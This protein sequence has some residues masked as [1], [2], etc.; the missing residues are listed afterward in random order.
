MD[1]IYLTIL[2]GFAASVALG[3]MKLKPIIGGAIAA[4]VMP[5]PF[6]IVNG[7]SQSQSSA[8]DMVFLAPWFVLFVAFVAL[9]SFAAGFVGMTLGNGIVGHGSLANRRSIASALACAIVCFVAY[10]GY[11]AQQNKERDP[12]I[13]ESALRF[14]TADPSIVLMAGA[15]ASVS[16]SRSADMADTN[17]WPSASVELGQ[18]RDHSRVDVLLREVHRKLSGLPFAELGLSTQRDVADVEVEP[19]EPEFRVWARNGAQSIE[20]WSLPVAPTKLGLSF[21]EV[22]EDLLTEFVPLSQAG[23]RER[24]GYDLREEPRSSWELPVGPSQSLQPTAYGGG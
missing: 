16:V 9:P 8:T 24:Y 22:Y 14:A 15:N 1:A 19:S 2:I 6:W 7:S 18:I 10:L 11:D 20:Y 4:G 3:T 17:A 13:L 12:V 5:I 21:K 23:W